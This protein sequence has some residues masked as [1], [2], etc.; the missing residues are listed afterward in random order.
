MGQLRRRRKAKSAESETS[1]KSARRRNSQSARNQAQI[2][3]S[4]T[5]S[6]DS[7]VFEGSQSQP[8]AKQVESQPEIETV[9]QPET[10]QSA[11]SA[12]AATIRSASGVV[13]KS[14]PKSEKSRKSA[15]SRDSQL[16]KNQSVIRKCPGNRN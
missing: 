8:K 3:R 11:G 12:L 4:A 10:S 5:I 2:P 14:L 16:A 6:G 7:G 13:E 9:S 15:K 1:R